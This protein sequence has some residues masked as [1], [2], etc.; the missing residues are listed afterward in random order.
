MENKVLQIAEP[1]NAVWAD[2]AMPAPEADEVVVRVAGIT[3][4]PHWDM[5]IYSG[6]P[7]FASRPISFPYTA[8][9]PGHEAC[10]SIA[11][12]GS[13]VTNFSEGDPV[14][15]WRDPGDRRQ[16]CYARF[17]AVKADQVLA[18]P[19]PIEPIK[20]ASLELAMCVQVSFD[21]L[22]SVNA[23]KGKHVLITGM[24]PAGLIAVQMANAY[25]ARAVTG[26]DIQEE[27]RELGKSVGATTCIHPD[28]L[29]AA[30]GDGD[31]DTG[32]D[33]TGISPVINQLIKV[34]KDTVAV[35]GVMREPIEVGPDHWWGGFTFM[36]YGEH[37]VEAAKRA[38]DLIVQNKLN[39][40]PLVSATLPFS[41]YG[42]GVEMLK[43][44]EAIKVLFDPWLD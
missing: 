3:T 19:K 41:K 25:G 40:E 31:F 39:L 44:K 34:T 14:V 2:A 37:N 24:G 26:T 29:P 43:S 16:G 33:T 23:I 27:R 13:S 8:G 4:C 5:R 20:I 32:L 22:N 42:E 15:L 7:M 30:F 6:T 35:F 12:V 11:S 10:G 18:L 1:G 17:V 38:L 36:G 28:D 21:Q 9:E